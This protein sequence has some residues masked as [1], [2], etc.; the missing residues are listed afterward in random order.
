MD[1]NSFLK[2]EAIVNGETLVPDCK[3]SC[4]NIAAKIYQLA[5][6]AAF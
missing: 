1:L 5:L 6:Y 4:L 3:L 2:K